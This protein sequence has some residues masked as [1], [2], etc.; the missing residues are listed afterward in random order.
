[1]SDYDEA[2]NALMRLEAALARIAAAAQEADDPAP[3][4]RLAELASGLDA[5]IMRL[6]AALE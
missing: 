3:D 5:V 1:M 2:Q 6:R 4:P